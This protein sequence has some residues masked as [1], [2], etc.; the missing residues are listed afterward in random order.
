MKDLSRFS[1]ISVFIIDFW[2]TSFKLCL[3]PIENWI[4]VDFFGYFGMRQHEHK[5]A[6][7]GM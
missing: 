6:S 7:N 3:R 5:K 4:S 1:L 2:I